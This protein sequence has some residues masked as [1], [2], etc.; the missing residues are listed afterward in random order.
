MPLTL[1]TVPYV[2]TASGASGGWSWV[3]PQLQVGDVMCAMA[4]QGS[5]QGGYSTDY[6]RSAAA[7]NVN[8]T[9]APGVDGLN[10]NGR[11][12]YYREAT[13]A[14]I[15]GTQQ[16][17]MTA[18]SYIHAWII[19][20]P[21]PG[22]W[23]LRDASMYAGSTT[24]R[25]ANASVNSSIAFKSYYSTY[26]GGDFTHSASASS[27]YIA[28]KLFGQGATIQTFPSCTTAWWDTNY[29]IVIFDEANTLPSAP[30]GVTATEGMENVY[31]SQVSWTHVDPDGD[32]QAK[33]QLRWR[34]GV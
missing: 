21:S 10:K 26:S 2:I 22:K 6:I 14:D 17:S 16:Y 24:S 23:T 1:P 13:A 5:A 18:T 8:W 3:A 27:H 29:P 15:G 28:H 11:T 30:S 9:K 4:V 19:R 33:Y 12:F 31:A 25:P 32:P 7:G 20:P 34:R